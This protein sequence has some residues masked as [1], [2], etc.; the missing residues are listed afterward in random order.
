LPATS[1]ATVWLPEL[2]AETVFADERRDAVPLS[3]SCA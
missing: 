1:R 2:G 3:A